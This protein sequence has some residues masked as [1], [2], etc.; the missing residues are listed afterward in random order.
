MTMLSTLLSNLLT[1]GF[2]ANLTIALE[3]SILA[4]SNFVA[5]ITPRFSYI[6]TYPNARKKRSLVTLHKNEN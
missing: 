6:H 2:L 1:A 5:K 3:D 4:V